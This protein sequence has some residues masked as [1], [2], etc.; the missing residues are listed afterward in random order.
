MAEREP[1]QQPEP[2][3]RRLRPARPLYGYRDIGAPAGARHTRQAVIRAWGLLAVL[4]VVYLA[5]VLT[6]YFV[7]PGLR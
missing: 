7:E 5:V 3:R 1:A 2:R 6:I 4:I